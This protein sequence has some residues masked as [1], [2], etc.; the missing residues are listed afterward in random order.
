MEYI[1]VWKFVMSSFQLLATMNR[2]R[3]TFQHTARLVSCSEKHL[4]Q[5]LAARLS[6]SWEAGAACSA[7]NFSQSLSDVLPHA[8]LSW[9]KFDTH[10]SLQFNMFSYKL[11]RCKYRR[12]IETNYKLSKF[13][14][15]KHQ[16]I[17][18]SCLKK[19][20]TM[21]KAIYVQYIFILLYVHTNIYMFSLICII[22]GSTLTL[23]AHLSLLAWT[24]AFIVRFETIKNTIHCLFQQPVSNGMS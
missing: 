1:A 22:Q 8:I 23:Y 21:S 9:S 2:V 16:K 6:S 18:L 10:S 5:E 19:N 20:K 24:E 12:R 15:S 13:C 7:H 11:Y 4:Q 3:F 14:H 17:D